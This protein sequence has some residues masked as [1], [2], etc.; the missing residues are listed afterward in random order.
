MK[1]LLDKDTNYQCIFEGA[2]TKTSFSDQKSAEIKR[3]DADYRQT[4]TQIIQLTNYFKV[5]SSP[6]SGAFDLLDTMYIP[7]PCASAHANLT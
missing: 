7:R 4:T 1:Y 2:V 5:Y 6:Y 3:Y